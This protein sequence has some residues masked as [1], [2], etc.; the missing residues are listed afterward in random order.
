MSYEFKTSALTNCIREPP[1][2]AHIARCK[3]R[4][5][6]LYIWRSLTTTRMVCQDNLLLS[7]LDLIVY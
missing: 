2:L 3:Y 6:F 5:V 7:T 1:T 4:V